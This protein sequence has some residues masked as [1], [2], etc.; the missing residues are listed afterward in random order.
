MLLQFAIC[1]SRAGRVIV[2]LSKRSSM[3]RVL[4]A[5]NHSRLMGTSE[6]IFATFC[7]IRLCPVQSSPPFALASSVSASGGE[8]ASRQW[9]LAAPPSLEPPPAGVPLLQTGARPD[10]PVA[11]GAQASAP[12]LPVALA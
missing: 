12:A 10:C 11:R 9:M 5:D 6:R 3:Y 2:S 7:I 4:L 1:I 8:G